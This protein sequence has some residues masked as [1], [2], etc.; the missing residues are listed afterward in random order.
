MKAV[1][2]ESLVYPKRSEAAAF[3]RDLRTVRTPALT[4]KERNKVIRSYVRRYL[5]KPKP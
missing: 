2:D 3:A 4:M 1:P 5:Q